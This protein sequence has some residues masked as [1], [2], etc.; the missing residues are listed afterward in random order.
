[1]TS[2]PSQKILDRVAKMLDLMNNPAASEGEIANANELIQR[3]C[4]EYNLTL[5]QVEAARGPTGG[6]VEKREKKLTDFRAMYEYQTTIMRS[7]AESNFCLWHI[8]KVFEPHPKAPAM[9]YRGEYLN[10]RMS[11]HHQLVGREVNVMITSQT[12]QYLLDALRRACGD[13]GYDPRTTDGKRFLEGA[14]SRI[15]ER[16]DE[17]RRQRIAEQDAAKAARAPVGNGSGKELVLSDV[18]GSESDLNNDAL[19]GFAPGTTAAERRAWHEK[20][21]RQDAERARLIAEGVNCDEAW[22][23]SRGYGEERAKEMVLADAKLNARARGGRGTRST[24]W[25]NA[26]REYARKVNST[27][28]NA[29]RDA[30]A[31][32]GLDQQM[33]AADRKRLTR[34]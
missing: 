5:S 17:R 8:K 9:W 22:Y 14:A 25:T 21:E 32:I 16:L 2:E 4:Q 29:G 3:T 31:S 30:G 33:G 20:Q 28:Y 19:N 10:G 18:Y 34:S 1:M 11:K 13:A 27:S 15:S 7:L 26:D 12:Y 6:P 23:R 24:G